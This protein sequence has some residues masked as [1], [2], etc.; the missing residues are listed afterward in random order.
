MLAFVENG[1]SGKAPDQIWST[2]LID[3]LC[4][5]SKSIT[6]LNRDM[7]PLFSDHRVPWPSILDHLGSKYDSLAFQDSS[8]VRHLIIPNRKNTDYILHFYFTDVLHHDRLVLCDTVSRE[9]IYN[10]V[11]SDLVDIIAT[12]ICV[13][14]FSQSCKSL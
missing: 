2:M 6:T 13:F 5:C 11:E 4:S 9:D 7:L 10:A 1:R 8:H 12:E 3:K 14:L